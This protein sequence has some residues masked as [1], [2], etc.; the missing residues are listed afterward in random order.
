MSCEKLCPQ[1]AAR[2]RPTSGA[3]PKE[4]RLGYGLV[5]VMVTAL[6]MPAHSSPSVP[7]V[8]TRRIPPPR[9]CDAEDGLWFVSFL[10]PAK[11]H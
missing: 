7:Y 6:D 2:Y 3:K 8:V 5:C 4:R 11:L 10:P 1:S 9:Q